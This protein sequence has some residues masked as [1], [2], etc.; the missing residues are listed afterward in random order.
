MRKIF[1]FILILI[2]GG[3]SGI[4]ASQ[5]LLPYLANTSPFDKISWFKKIKDGTTIINKTEKIVITENEALDKA[6][7]KAENI[8]VGVISQR[9]EKII[10]RKKVVLEKPEILASGTGFIVSSDGLVVTSNNLIPETAQKIL[11]VFKSKDILAE[12]KKRDINSGLA[13][14]KINESNLPVLPFSEQ[15]LRLAE[16]LFLVGAKIQNQLIKFVDLSLVKQLEPELMVD[17]SSQDINGSPLFN[18][19]GEV[20]GMNLI[21]SSGQAKVVL[22]VAIRELLR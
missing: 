5:F 20:I 6:V 21:D 18:I 1:N 11:V 14:L 7:S 13:L 19:K 16:R 15:E 8:V 3:L 2:V 12:L 9:T 22:L 17:F 4:L 10:A